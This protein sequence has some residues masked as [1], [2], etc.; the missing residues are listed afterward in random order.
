MTIPT[1]KASR[2][3]TSCRRL[4]P[5]C[6]G[7]APTTWTSTRSTALTTRP[8]SKKR[9]QRFFDRGLVVQA[10]DLV[11]VH[12]VG[13]EPAQAGVNRLHDVLA[14]ESFLVGIVIHGEENFGGDHQLLPRR[15]K[16]FERAAQDLFADAERI[17]V[18]GV[19]EIDAQIERLL[20]EW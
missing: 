8:R 2:A 20:D 11:E 7:S 15:P 18:G 9:C 3:S 12:V 10:V 16:V 6:A 13:A 5:A 4:T 1:K 17:H 14:R 19:K